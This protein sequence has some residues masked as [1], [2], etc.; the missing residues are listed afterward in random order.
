MQNL[1]LGDKN[2]N[3]PL[4]NFGF[5]NVKKSQ[6]SPGLK[7]LYFPRYLLISRKI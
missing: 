1:D 7:L 6:N 3:C 5:E 4:Q 2:T